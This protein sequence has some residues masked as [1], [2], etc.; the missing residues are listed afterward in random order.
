MAVRTREHDVNT[1][2]EVTPAPVAESNPPAAIPDYGDDA[3]K[4]MEKV[5]REEQRVPFIRVLQAKSPT[6]E[7]GSPTKIP[8]HEPGMFIHMGTQEVWP[9]DGTVEFIACFRE[10]D[11]VEW[12]PMT[13]GRDGGLVGRRGWYDPLVAELRAKQGR[14]GKL[15]TPDGNEIAQTF[16]LYGLLIPPG[17]AVR[18]VV[19]GFSSTQIK[20]YQAVID[21]VDSLKFKKDG[22]V[23]QPPLYAWRWKLSTVAEHKGKN[24]WFGIRIEPVGKTNLDSLMPVTSDLYMMARDFHDLM[25]TGTVDAAVEQMGGHGGA[26]QEPGEDDIPM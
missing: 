24:N 10:K 22:K 20:K 16:Y 14:F 21:R 2:K 3:G 8:G 12:V 26:E 17:E 7:V 15:T 11:Y 9:G 13:E 5:D 1:E 23:R 25:A 19:I 18:R 4:G 6:A